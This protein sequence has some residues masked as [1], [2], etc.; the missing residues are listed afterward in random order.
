[1]SSVA[2]NCPA[3]GEPIVAG[4]AFCESCGSE[5]AS[6]VAAPVPTGSPRAE[7]FPVPKTTLSQA[8]G[9]ADQCLECSGKVLD[10]GFCSQC[11]KKAPSPRDHWQESP[12]EWIGGVCDK[13]VVHARNEDA[14]A[15]AGLPDRSLAVLVVC[16]G[17]TSAP[18]S[19][20]AALAAAREACATLSGTPGP[21]AGGVAATVSH[22]GVAIE[23]ACADAN[24]AAIGVARALGNP[25]EPPSC[26]F[27]AAVVDNGV[28]TLGWCGDSRAYW[29]PDTGDAVQ[30]MLDH[31]LGTE[32]IQSGMSRSD[33]ET[34]PTFHTI[35]RW[36]GADSVDATP[37]IA[38]HQLTE[39]GWLL[40]CSDGLW[41]YASPAV[42]VQSLVHDQVAAGLSAPVAIAA[43]LVRW[44]NEQGGHDN[45]TAALAR[46]EPSLR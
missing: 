31:S 14:M 2:V 40:L 23:R 26:T 42:A 38:S 29:L 5:L 12:V 13:G 46:V 15:L 27:I 1:M 24:A 36:L 10:D 6:A 34:D 41:N 28:V 32:L 44:A 4:D 21:V 16:D 45:I 33:A 7:S 18:D 22:W 25:S 11:G 43:A 19:D 37:D 3:C 30:L 39:P 9:I 35:T 17:V 20:R 8:P